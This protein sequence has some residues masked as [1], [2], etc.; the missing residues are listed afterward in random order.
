M[1]GA[2]VLIGWLTEAVVGAAVFS[3]VVAVA[4]I[5]YLRAANPDRRGRLRMAAHEAH[6]HG[7]SSGTRHVLVIAN[8]VL[9][10]GE[11]RERIL[12]REEERIEVDILAPVLTSQLHY[13]VS[14]IDRELGEARARLESSL[15]W[16]RKQG[17]VARGEV[18]DPSP[19]TAIEDA[20]RDFGADEVIVVTHPEERETWQ[21]R[22][23][24]ERLR[25]ELDVPVTHVAVGEGGPRER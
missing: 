18:G 2:A 7:A 15:T 16:A 23:E 22:G 6:P 1:I 4:V 11:L 5:A 13:G 10:G 21:E 9:S 8:E 25:R 17:I 20:L 19:T 3:L 12:G 14:D 24:L